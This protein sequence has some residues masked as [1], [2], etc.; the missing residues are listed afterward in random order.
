MRNTRVIQHLIRYLWLQLC[1]EGHVWTFPIK[2]KNEPLVNWKYP[3]EYVAIVTL[4]SKNLDYYLITHFSISWIASEGTWAALNRWSRPQ[5]HNIARILLFSALRIP[6]LFFR[7]SLGHSL[8]SSSF[9][10]SDFLE[11]IFVRIASMFIYG[12]FFLLASAVSQVS[13]KGKEFTYI[14]NFNE[15]NASSFWALSNPLFITAPKK[16]PAKKRYC[17]S[18]STI[19]SP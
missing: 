10:P 9:M 15:K 11:Y 12:L 7:S 4:L 17:W 14:G 8:N 2:M 3:I 1:Y 16:N 13:I 5:G 19:F 6:L 18:K